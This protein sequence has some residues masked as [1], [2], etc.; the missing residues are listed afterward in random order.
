[1]RTTRTSAAGY[2]L[3]VAEGGDPLAP[4]HVLVHGIG[5]SARY[6]RPLADALEPDSHV[7]V[8]D[9]PGF[10]RSPDPEHAL[11]V[12]ELADV[13]ATLVTDRGLVAPVLVGH[14]MGAQVV[15]EVLASRPG[16]AGGAV[17]IGPVVDVDARSATRQAV[18]LVRD[19]RHEPLRSNVV[20]FSDYLR[21]GP[22]RYI[23][24][25]PHMLGYA[26]HERLP[27]AAEPVVVVRGEHDT[28]A[29][30][31]WVRHLAA[32]APRGSAAEVPDAGHVAMYADPERVRALC[33]GVTC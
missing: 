30:S 31:S 18:R 25:L 1:M 21:C 4:A 10:G 20:V 3:V 2:E 8:P 11:D 32:L 7:L 23:A 19:L 27:L 28:V 33:R 9:L 12:A 6:F 13:V 15:T 16:L 29:P 22:R 26:I 14:S 24:T 5:V 17:L